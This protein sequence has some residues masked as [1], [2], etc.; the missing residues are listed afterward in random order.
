M[1]QDMLFTG[2]RVGHVLTKNR[3]FMA[4]MTRSRSIYPGDVPSD[5]NAIYYAQRASAGLIVSEGTQVSPTAQ[6][7]LFTPGI[8]SKEQVAG[9]K[10]VTKAVHDKGGLIAAQLWHVGRISH[11]SVLPAGE[12]PVGASNIKAHSKTF[13]KNDRDEIGMVDCSEPQ[14]LT[15]EGIKKLIQ[16]FV[17][18]ASNAHEAGFDLVEIH[19]A[20][21][22][23]FNQFFATQTNNRTD[24]YGGSIEN[25]ARLI[26]EV[27]DAMIEDRKMTADRIG[28][29]V[30]F[31]FN[32]KK[33][34]DLDDSNDAMEMNTYLAK[35]FSKRGLAFIHLS[36][37]TPSTKEQRQQIR[38]NFTGTIIVAGEYTK[39][40]AEEILKSGLA[41]AVAFGR[42]FISNPDLPY[43]LK[44]NIELTPAKYETF[45]GGDEKG[46]IDYPAEQE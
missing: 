3:I 17:H 34:N 9:W 42:P 23:L 28:V 21:G 41:D 6:G 40:R 43:K 24:E 16:E 45:Y 32:P 1:S 18:A 7:Y 26:L 19:A 14:A 30:S 44:M 29:R 12:N 10:K 8:Y 46:Y 13:G 39:E 4:P 38:D 33:I 5:M 31:P 36:E 11:S 15:K 37:W 27:I 2:V 20:N 22:Y 35:E 25:R